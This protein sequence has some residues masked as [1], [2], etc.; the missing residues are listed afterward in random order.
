MAGARSSKVTA[1]RSRDVFGQPS[2]RR[3]RAA[4]ARRRARDGRCDTRRAS[5]AHHRASLFRPGGAELVDLRQQFLGELLDR[6]GFRFRRALELTFPGAGR[7]AEMRAMRL[8]LVVMMSPRY[9]V[10]NRK[11]KCRIERGIAVVA[12]R[13][14]LL[15][16]A[17][18]YT[19]RMTKK[20]LESRIARLERRATL[21]QLV[22][23]GSALV[24]GGLVTNACGK[25]S[26][27]AKPTAPDQLQLGNGDLMV[28]IDQNK[29]VM[30][31][32][33]STLTLDSEGLEVSMTGTKSTFRAGEIAIHEGTDRVTRMTSGRMKLER[34][35]RTIDADVTKDKEVWLVAS[36]NSGRTKMLT[37]VNDAGTA[38]IE[39][40]SMPDDPTKGPGDGVQMGTDTTKG[41]SLRVYKNAAEKY[42]KLGK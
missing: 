41:P 10:S 19:R 27:Q 7:E 21:W 39:T 1:L 3:A 9:I 11:K 36:A 37:W 38:T 33:T 34:E 35:G 6:V 31:G 30:T 8:R 13:R 42:F 18:R 28:R 4:A 25:S 15:R 16:T 5:R 12:R 22:A 24:T 17:G 20:D 40:A 29:L 2:R 23:I 26:P 32:P 14:R